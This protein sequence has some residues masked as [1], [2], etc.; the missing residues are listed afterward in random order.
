MKE[1]TKLYIFLTIHI[2]KI[3]YGFKNISTKLL[4]AQ[5]YHETGGF[6]SKVYK[7][8]KNLFG[9]RQPKKRKTF[10]TGTKNNHAIF[11]TLAASIRDYFLRQKEF[12][13][14]NQTN[15]SFI[16][17]TV[18]SGYAEDKKYKSKW[19]NVFQT[20]KYP[21]KLLFSILIVFVLIFITLRFNP[22]T[23]ILNNLFTKNH[24]NKKTKQTA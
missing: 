23:N 4:Y 18:N 8:N 12:N 5:A 21:T 19:L 15:D 3:Y 24:V 14:S 9:M 22:K 6:T 17:E 16:D 7:E 10:A 1:L 13:I 2:F 20:I 11:K